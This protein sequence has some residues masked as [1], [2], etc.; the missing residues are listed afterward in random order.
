[1]GGKSGRFSCTIRVERLGVAAASLVGPSSSG[2]SLSDSI[3]LS[4]EE[5]AASEIALR[6]LVKE[7]A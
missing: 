4:S 1:M 3:E 6:S 7:V 5:R 2:A